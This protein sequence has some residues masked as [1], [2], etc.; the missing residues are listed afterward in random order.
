[1]AVNPTAVWRIRPSGSDTNGGGYDAAIS[2]AGTDYSQQNSAQASGTHLTGTTSTVTDATAANFTSAMV[3]NAMFITGGGSTAGFYFITAFTSSS[4]VTLDRSP[5]AAVTNATFH[6]GGGWATIGGN[7]TGAPLV[8][9]NKVYILG[10]GIPNPASYVYDYTQAGFNGASGSATTG[11]ILFAADTATPSYGSGGYPTIKLSNGYL[12]NA[13]TCIS[14]QGLWFVAT[15]SLNNG[16]MSACASSSADKC[17]LDQFGFAQTWTGNTSTTLSL[18]RLEIFNSTGSG[19][20]SASYA[21]SLYGDDGTMQGC[22][23]HDALT[24]GVDVGNSCAIVGNIFSNLKGSAAAINLGSIAG[25]VFMQ[26]VLNNT[27]DNGL[28]SG[29]VVNNGGNV[30]VVSIHNN[31]ISNMTASG[32]FGLQLTSQTAAVNNALN[33]GGFID[34]NTYYGNTTD[35]SGI[36][37]GGNDTSNSGTA[38]NTI[39]SSPYV[40]SSTENYTLA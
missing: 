19:T 28:G 5:G 18:R 7:T 16:P 29:I 2:G 14:L 6:V 24:N 20:P 9:G 23:I 3:G 1:M 40:A 34:N 37:Y 25:S 30:P 39:A 32:K 10:S 15:S 8:G 22:N 12:F 35:T 33:L 36:G 31:I 4:V 21:V 11:I 26:T 13:C 38:P 27:I 17:V